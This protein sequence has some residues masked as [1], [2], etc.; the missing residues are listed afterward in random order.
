MTIYNESS[1]KNL[2]GLE[3]IR[4][5]PSGYI[6]DTH[7]SGT[8]HLLK[9]ILDNS[10]DELSAMNSEKGLLQVILFINKDKSSYQGVVIDNGRGIPIGKLIDVF[11][12]T[13]TSGKFDTSVYRTSAGSFG[14]GASV[15]VALSKWFRA[16]TMN[17]GKI[18]DATIHYDNIPENPM[19][20]ETPFDK[21][22]TIVF[23]E[24]DDTI[25]T[26]VPFFSSDFSLLTDYMIQLSLFNIYQ[27]KLFVVNNELPKKYRKADTIDTIS[28]IDSILQGQPF[29]DSTDPSFDRKA[30]INSYFGVTKKW[31]AVFDIN[32]SFEDI[33]KVKGELLVSLSNP[34]TGNTRLTMVNDIL[35]ND[36]ASYHITDLNAALKSKLCEY[37]QEKRIKQFFLEIYKLPIWLSMDIRFSGALFSGLAKTSFKDFKF[38]HPYNTL[39]NK[40]LTKEMISNIYHLIENHIKNQYDKWSN[41]DFRPSTTMK[42]LLA[43]LNRP[44]KF[45]NCSTTNREEA[46][47]FLVEGDSAKIDQDRDSRFQASYTLG[48]K[49][50]NGLTFP[51]R[52]EDSIQ[53]IKTN[54]VFE[55]IVRILNITPG[56]NNLSNLNFAKTFITADA[57]THGYHI[58]NIVIGNLYMLCPELINQGHVY[59]VIPPLYSLTIKGNKPIYIRNEDELNVTLA[60]HVYYRCLEIELETPDVQVSNIVR[61]RSHILSREEFVVFC[62]LVNK[63]GDELK[64]LSIEYTI[65]AILLEQLALMTNH[66]NLKNPN[67]M[68]IQKL[69]GCEVRYVQ[70]SNIIIVSIG[71]ED[72]V[73]PL[74][75]ITDLIYSRILPLYREFYYS[76][77]RIYATTK[78]SIAMSRSPVS[79][80]Q[81]YSIFEELRNLFVIERYKGLGSMESPD[82]IVNCTSPK[83]RRVFRITS[84]GDLDVVFDMLGNDPSERKKLLSGN[85]M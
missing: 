78:N 58:T 41:V 51:N 16:I 74:N 28:Y 56:S 12:N 31:D 55:D 67:I 73:V 57:D 7:I 36:N 24:P 33:L 8:F 15:S 22:G 37:I 76:K 53:A 30:Y 59:V 14:V 47:L 49:P 38:K 32:G 5:R 82:K 64:R 9:E 72:I 26:G 40:V 35:F 23:H 52:I 25:L 46:E 1:I 68:M 63:I 80:M 70:S 84:I 77:T 39:L 42:G 27:L 60:Y 71:S 54:H 18:A 3:H 66:L 81:L 21:T 34:F 43:K 65:P 61:R 11:A 50:F 83:T 4:L 69:L 45:F 48:G 79:I 29:F 62:E 6:N 44:S 2:T 13:M 17:N 19:I 75:Q 85:L 10:V 20:I